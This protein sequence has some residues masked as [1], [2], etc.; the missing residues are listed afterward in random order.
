MSNYEA[1]LYLTDHK[2]RRMTPDDKT[3][4]M[5]CLEEGRQAMIEET[6][7]AAIAPCPLT[8][9]GDSTLSFDEPGGSG[10]KLQTQGRLYCILDFCKSETHHPVFWYL[11]TIQFWPKICD[12]HP[13]FCLNFIILTQNYVF[14]FSWTE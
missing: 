14:L 1:F 5:K 11:G 3:S 2:T 4:L 9:R 12:T 8:N 6:F 13:N 7:N 10:T